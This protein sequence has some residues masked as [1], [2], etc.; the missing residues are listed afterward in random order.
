MT[1]DFGP[2]EKVKQRLLSQKADFE[3]QLGLIENTDEGKS[4]TDTHASLST[5]LADTNAALG[6]LKEGTYGLCTG[7]G[8]EIGRG[9]LESIPH[10]ALCLPCKRKENGLSPAGTTHRST[11]EERATDA[12][13]SRPC[14]KCGGTIPGHIVREQPDLKLCLNCIPTEKQFTDLPIPNVQRGGNVL[15]SIPVEKIRPSDN[16]PRSDVGDVSEL[17]DSI[18]SIGLLQRVVVRPQDDGS[19]ELISGHRRLA[20]V[21]KLGWDSIPAEVQTHS[22]RDVD[23]ARLV[24]NLHREDLKPVDEARGFQRLAELHGMSQREIAERVACSQSHVSKRLALL[25]LPID[26]LHALESDDSGGITL[27]EA[28]TLLQ[29]REH[30]KRMK[31]AFDHRSFSSIDGEVTRHLQAIRLEETS[32]AS[33]EKLEKAGVQVLDNVPYG[34]KKIARLGRSYSDLPIKVSDHAAEP[35]HAATVSSVDGK[36]KYVCTDLSRHKPSG[37]SALKAIRPMDDKTRRETGVSSSPEV[38][39]EREARER[40]QQQRESFVKELLTGP[41]DHGDLAEL[42][43]WLS[44]EYDRSSHYAYPVLLITDSA[45]VE[46]AARYLGLEPSIEGEADTVEAAEDADEATAA[47]IAA[48]ANVSVR[49]RT[50]AALALVL[51]AIELSIEFGAHMDLAG[52]QPYFDFLQRNGYE[53]SPEERSLVHAE[54]EKEASVG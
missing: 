8:E 6:R 10:V 35:C 28:E 51:S 16:N 50:R 22:D 33:K 49:N 52:F 41:V 18:A 9:R 2:V 48:F 34:D 14:E 27:T 53:L 3:R 30:P 17:A 45:D 38:I 43:V 37:K 24:E 12:Q 23:V 20:A 54:K 42:L 32:K 46:R 5:L 21:T 19:F 47:E 40:I 29:L 26:A 15:D 39:E 4:M 31:N 13:R 25:A 44:T 1:V 7:C 11:A 36:S